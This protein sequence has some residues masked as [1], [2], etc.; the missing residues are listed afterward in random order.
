M[1]HLKLL[2]VEEKQV[3]NVEK[4]LQLK[5]LLVSNQCLRDRESVWVFVYPFF[6]LESIQNTRAV[7][8]HHKASDRS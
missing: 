5:Q 6:W 2:Q 3:G 7:I 8:I 4:M 1:R